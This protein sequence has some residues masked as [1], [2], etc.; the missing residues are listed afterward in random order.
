MSAATLF[1]PGGDPWYGLGDLVDELDRDL[2]HAAKEVLSYL[3][4]RERDGTLN[5]LVTD[6][7]IAEAIGYSE[8]FVQKGLNAL[9]VQLGELGKAIID[10][11]PSHGRRIITFVRGLAGRGRSG[12]QSTPPQTPPGS[13][14]KTTTGFPSS[15]FEII[16]AIAELIARACRLIPEA[17]PGKVAAAVGDFGAEWVGRALDRVEERNRRP[18]KLPVKSWGFVLGVLANYRREGGPAPQRPVPPTQP[19]VAKA[20]E[21]SPSE[22][23]QPL[24]AEQVAELVEQAGSPHRAMARIATANLRVSVRDG[25]IPPE[26]AATI[27]AG[28]LDPEDPRA[29]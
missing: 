7:V 17:T 19:A 8:R 24:T 27:P 6:R 1:R 14:E 28:I 18:G 2:R 16:P 9:H 22:P 20:S 11:V 23:P 15:S 21:A 4:K 25:L 29:P 10:R 5:E 3:T 13:F 26:L 12:T